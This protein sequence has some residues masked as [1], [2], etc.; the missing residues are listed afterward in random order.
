MLINIIAS[1]YLQLINSIKF[2]LLRMLSESLRV[3][4]PQVIFKCSQV[5]SL[6]IL[7]FCGFVT[8]KPFKR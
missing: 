7:S 6:S 4:N 8:R 5:L 1:I 2:I 3:C